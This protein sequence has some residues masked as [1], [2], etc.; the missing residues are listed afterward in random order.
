M[1]YQPRM[2]YTAT[3]LLSV[4]I[5]DNQVNPLLC[6]TSRMLM[7]ICILFLRVVFNDFYCF[8]L[9][10]CVVWFKLTSPY[11]TYHC[12]RYHHLIM[13]FI[14]DLLFCHQ[15]VFESVDTIIGLLWPSVRILMKQPK[16]IGIVMYYQILVL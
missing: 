2:S 4:L 3:A 16:E 7:N 1:R 11:L 5:T 10:V 14:A 13:Y 8:L 12:I 6:L 15:V 9:D